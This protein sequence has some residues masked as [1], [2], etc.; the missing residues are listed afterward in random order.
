MHLGIFLV[1]FGMTLVTSSHYKLGFYGTYMGDHFGIFLEKRVTTF[2]F[3]L[4]DNP[5][6][7]GSF[8]N[9]LGFGLIIKSMVVVILSFFALLIYYTFL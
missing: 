9:M 5:M 7:I 2:P 8:M 3:N 1:I 4:V 6:Y